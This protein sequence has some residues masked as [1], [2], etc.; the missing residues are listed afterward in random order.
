MAPLKVL[1]IELL[2]CWRVRRPEWISSASR[3]IMVGGT[4]P[5]RWFEPVGSL[6]FFSFTSLS[7]FSL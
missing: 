2:V 6:V 3:D 5:R 7:G 1:S 4:E